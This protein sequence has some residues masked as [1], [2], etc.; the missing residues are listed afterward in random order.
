[1]TASERAIPG[2]PRDLVGYGSRPPKVVW[3]NGAKVAVNFVVNY[4]E[5]S[6]HYEY[7]GDASTDPLAE[8]DYRIDRRYRDFSIESVYEYGSRA[9]I[10]RLMRL[11]AEYGVKSTIFA[12]GMA[13]EANPQ[14]GRAIQEAGHEAC[15]HGYRWSEPWLFTEEEERRE[16]VLAVDSIRRTCGERPVGWY[17]RYSRSLRS[18][19]LL[20][21]EGGFLYDSDAYND[22]LPYFDDVNGKA[23]LVVPYTQVYN[24]IR[25]VVAGGGVS[26]PGIFADFCKRALDELWREGAAGYPK[27]M[28]LGLHPRLI[29]Q[30]GRASGLREFVEYAL[31]KGDVWLARRV[32]I[33][34][35]W[36]DHHHE[37]ER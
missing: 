33:A 5:G 2:P 20:V 15:A 24:D 36:L 21:D 34:R 32:D 22:D 7:T 23:H 8:F 37:F 11:F 35:W 9:G 10:W 4:E 29:G 18:R 1:V 13:L 12:C 28:T 30:A 14:V 31:E 17:W 16:I 27:M 26:G 25:F 3:P 6:E 19:E